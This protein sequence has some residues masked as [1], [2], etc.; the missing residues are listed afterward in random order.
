MNHAPRNRKPPLGIRLMHLVRRDPDVSAMSPDEVVAF[1]AS[2]IRLAES[3]AARLLTGRPARGVTI[4]WEHLARPDRDIRVRVYRPTAATP[5]P[6]PL[7]LHVHG[8]GFMGTAVQ[9][10]WINSHLAARLSAVVVSV[11]HR[12]VAP[13]VPMSAAVDDGWDALRHLVEHAAEWGVDP[14]RFAVAG[15]SAGGMIAAMTAIRA[16]RSGVPLRAQVLVNPCVDLTATALDH[17][18][19]TEYADTP[20]LTVERLKAFRR[21][22]VSGDADARGISPLH[23]DDLSG[24][25]PA[26]VVIPVLDPLADHGRVYADRLREAGTPAEVSEH[27]HAGHAFISMPTLVPQAK[28]ARERITGFLRTHLAATAARGT[29]TP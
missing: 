16:A 9:C 24:L 15:E 2:Q 21:L 29:R 25:A 28:D 4:G 12:L 6:L 27:D 18:S 5:A 20:T 11:E 1:A 22:A 7:L 17:P 19:M 3:R 26:L 23:A 14:A 8:G 13:G 10:D